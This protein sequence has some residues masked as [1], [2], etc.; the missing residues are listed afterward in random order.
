MKSWQKTYDDTHL[1]S[2]QLTNKQ[3]PTTSRKYL[4]NLYNT[5]RENNSR[6]FQIQTARSPTKKEMPNSIPDT[7]HNSTKQRDSGHNQL[8]WS[9]LS[10]KRVMVKKTSKRKKIK[11]IAFACFL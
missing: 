3:A 1:Q 11:K 10:I 4:L 6:Q 7:Q 9:L 2:R 5:K 8:E